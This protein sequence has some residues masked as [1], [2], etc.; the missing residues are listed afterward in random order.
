MH[1]LQTGGQAGRQG[2]AV[3]IGVEGV[4]GA[5]KGEKEAAA[6]E[7]HSPQLI[8]QEGKEAR[9]RMGGFEEGKG[10]PDDSGRVC[11]S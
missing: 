6:A 1:T 8:A 5:K 10:E 3:G 9:R 11:G 4:E 2:K 7:Y